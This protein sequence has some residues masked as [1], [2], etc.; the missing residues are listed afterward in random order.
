MIQAHI[1]GGLADDM[2]VV[3]LISY[4]QLISTDLFLELAILSCF[5]GWCVLH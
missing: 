3:L 4:K 1:H 5:K 2:M